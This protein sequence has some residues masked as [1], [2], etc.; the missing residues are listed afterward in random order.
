MT[1]QPNKKLKL[2]GLYTH[3]NPQSIEQYLL[4]Y[5]LQNKY[6]IQDYGLENRFVCL[7]AVKLTRRRGGGGGG[8]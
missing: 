4:S 6:C 1:N 8:V 5:L 2:A 7:S 3:G